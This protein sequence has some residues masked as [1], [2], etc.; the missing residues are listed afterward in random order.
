MITADYALEQGKEVFALPGRITD[1]LSGGCNRLLQTG[2]A[3]L[4]S[5]SDVLDFLG[6]K[7]EKKLTDYKNT[8]KRLAKNENLVYSFLDSRPKHFDAIVSAC[9]L[10]MAECMESLFRL[11]LAGIVNKTGNQYYSRKM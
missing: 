4:L 5:P 6:L 10:S 11:E 2:A 1:P 9:G 8:E 7:Y 3:V